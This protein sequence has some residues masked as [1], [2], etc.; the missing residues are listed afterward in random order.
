MK[1]NISNQ[2]YHDLPHA[3]R[4]RRGMWSWKATQK[5][6]GRMSELKPQIYNCCINSCI[7]Y[8][9]LR[10]TNLHVCL[11][12]K[13][14]RLN[15]CGCPQHRFTYIPLIPGLEA[16]LANQTQAKRM[17][18]WAE[19]DHVEDIIKDIFNGNFYWP[20]L[21]QHVHPVD[22]PAQ[23]HCYFEA[24]TNV[25]LGLLTDGYALFC[26]HAKTAWPV[27]V[28]NHN[29]PPK[30]CFHLDNVLCL[31]VISGPKKLQDFDSFL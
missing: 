11:F 25:V 15:S 13:E 17:R 8:A 29:L 7:C 1:H 30:I 6:I 22:G 14:R 24:K 9:G 18:Y 23:C 10:Y 3:R 20:L 4:N 28:F 31:G 19:F 2:A 5:H 16:F 27:L 12:C 26:Q 21:G